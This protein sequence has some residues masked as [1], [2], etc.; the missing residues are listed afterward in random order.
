M[1]RTACRQASS[2]VLLSSRGEDAVAEMKAKASPA[3]R[4]GGPGGGADSGPGLRGTCVPLLV[5]PA[6]VTELEREI[7]T[8]QCAL[9]ESDLERCHGNLATGLNSRKQTRGFRHWA[10]EKRKALTGDRK[11]LPAPPPPSPT[12]VRE[13]RGG[14]KGLMKQVSRN[15]VIHPCPA[16]KV[17]WGGEGGQLRVRVQN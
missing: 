2:R 16:G 10:G 8:A 6:P 15:A 7:R 1:E 4:R 17:R 3:S 5:K 12:D 14:V 9:R 13:G 11:A